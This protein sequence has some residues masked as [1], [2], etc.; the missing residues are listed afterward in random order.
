M[1]ERLGIEQGPWLNMYFPHAALN[2]SPCWSNCLK[3]TP[4]T[5]DSSLKAE[6]LT[7]ILR[8]QGMNAL[9]V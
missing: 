5:L 4:M 2:L 9:L 6:E 1:A 7:A 8:S 3:I